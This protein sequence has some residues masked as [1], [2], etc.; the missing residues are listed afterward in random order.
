MPLLL[1]LSV[2]PYYLQDK[3]Q[4]PWHG[5]PEIHVLKLSAF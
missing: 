5:P 4:M 3:I 2:A 1:K